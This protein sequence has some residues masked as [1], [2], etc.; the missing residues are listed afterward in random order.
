MPHC[1]GILL[2]VGVKILLDEWSRPIGVCA[3]SYSFVLLKVHTVVSKR[4]N[5]LPPTGLTDY[6]PRYTLR[7]QSGNP[8]ILTMQKEHDRLYSK[9]RRAPT[10]R[11]RRWWRRTDAWG[12]STRPRCCGRASPEPRWRTFRDCRLSRT[13]SW[14]CYSWQWWWWSSSNSWHRLHCSIYIKLVKNL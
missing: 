7:N 11:R 2:I 13:R 6:R 12:S 8:E 1:Q 3:P 14:K 9:T 5:E 10:A 4:E